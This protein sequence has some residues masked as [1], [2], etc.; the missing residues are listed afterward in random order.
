MPHNPRSLAVTDRYR[1]RLL[2]ARQGLEQ[3][4]KVRWPTIEQLDQTKWRHQM[5]QMV[6]QRQVEAIRVTSAYLT[7]FLSLE[8]GRRQLVVINSTAFAGRSRDGRPLHEALQSPIIGVRAKLK[9]GADP[10]EALRFGLERA[11]RMVGVDFDNAHRTALLTTIDLDRRFDGWQRAVRG[12][13][14]ACAAVAGKAE[15]GV[16]FQVH[17]GCQCV[18]EP[19]VA[20][21]PNTHPR[22]TGAEIFAAKDDQEQDEMLGPEAAALVRS[23]AIELSDLVGHSHLDSEQDDFITQ[24]PIE[25]LNLRP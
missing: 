11:V 10:T 22:P 14:G 12:T 24:R 18:S 6:S 15:H 3:Q 17:P 19:V 5:S 23:G 1:D 20:G 25:S 21:V 8:T 2:A 4:A 7:A 9:D 13:C 16:H